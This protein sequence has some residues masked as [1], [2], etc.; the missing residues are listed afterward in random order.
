MAI[1]QPICYSGKFYV[2]QTDG[3]YD[4][5]EDRRARPVHFRSIAGAKRKASQLNEI[6][7]CKTIL[8]AVAK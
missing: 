2:Q 3:S 7:K 1:W 4:L 6:E 5:Y 8:P